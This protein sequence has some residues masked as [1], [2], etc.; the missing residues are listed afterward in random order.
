MATI[1]ISDLRPTGS[2]L[3]FDSESFMDELIDG[4]IGIYGGATPA[5][6]SSMPCFYAS[7]KVTAVAL[8]AGAAVSGAIAYWAR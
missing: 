1:N 6:T 5:A 4:E 7:V 2:A 3:F 8:A